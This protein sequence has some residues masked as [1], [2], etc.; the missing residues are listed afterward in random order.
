MEEISKASAETSNIIKTID[1][2]AFQTNLLALNAAVEAARAG[3]AGAGFAVVADEVRSLAMRS[4]KAA[5]DTTEL[6]ESTG[7]KVKRGW[8]LVKTTNEAFTQAADTSHKTGDLVSEI[9]SASNE[10]AEGIEQ[11]QKALLEMDKVTQQNATDAEESA[12]ASEQ[13]NTQAKQMETIVE[14]LSMLA[15]GNGKRHAS[16]KKTPPLPC[17]SHSDEPENISQATG[18]EKTDKTVPA[19]VREIRPEQVIPL[20]EENNFNEL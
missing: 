20:D 10:Q 13:M 14:E 9:A 3:E 16:L 8:D 4:A 12:A 11:L 6:I 5:K 7:Q 15:G 17:G 2:I 18:E 1:E 19:K